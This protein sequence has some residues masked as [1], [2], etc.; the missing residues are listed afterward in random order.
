LTSATSISITFEFQK[1]DIR[2]ETVHQYATV[3][4]N[5]CRVK[6]WAKVVRRVLSYPGCDTESLVSTVLT[7][8]KRW[9]VTAAFLATQLQ[10]AAKRIGHDVLGFSHLDVGTHPIRSGGAM[11]MYLTGVRLIDDM[12]TGCSAAQNKQPNVLG[13]FGKINSESV[14]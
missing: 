3:L 10:A 5:L 1:T 4:P 6:A 7:N 8:N 12:L 13:W 2:N 14:Q 9:L 11:A